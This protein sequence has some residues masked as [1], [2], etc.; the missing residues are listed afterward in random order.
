MS[1]N[2][3]ISDDRLDKMLKNY[4]NR[5]TSYAF[6]AVVEEKKPKVKPFYRY[7]AACVCAAALIC[8]G[9]F[10]VGNS[11]RGQPDGILSGSTSENHS[12]SVFLIT[13][14]AA[15]KDG[16][17]LNENFSENLTPTVLK[18]NV[19]V[20]LS[21]YNLF[22]SSVPGIP[23]TVYT[24]RE[25]V[26]T[27]SVSCTT[28]A[29]CRWERSTGKITEEGSDLT[30]TSGET[31]Y[32]RPALNEEYKNSGTSHKWNTRENI[33]SVSQIKVTAVNKRTKKTGNQ[34][35]IIGKDDI[36]YFAV[37]KETK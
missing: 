27:L 13:A 28:G 19:E 35:V 7:A 32:W 3:K 30:C 22:M 16:D 15:E 11:Y 26:V 10:A 5:K 6:N 8:S 1:K 20:M 2:N 12:T 33:E 34:L 37:L 14:Y 29:F 17:N 23:L 31:I 21:S 18:P 36:N 4:C 24:D 9:F 25:D